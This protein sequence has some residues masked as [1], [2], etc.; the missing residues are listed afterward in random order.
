MNDSSQFSA[1]MNDIGAVCNDKNLDLVITAL[2]VSLANVGVSS[3]IEYE[4]FLQK[5]LKVITA[6]YVVNDMEDDGTIH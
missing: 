1:L 5:V 6:F 2:S 3:N 4:L